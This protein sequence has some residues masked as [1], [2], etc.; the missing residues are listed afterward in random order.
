MNYHALTT[1]ALLI[2]LL[3]LSGVT[4]RAH[5]Y[6]VRAIPADQ[7][8]LERAPARVQVW[9]SEELEPA[10]SALTLRDPNGTILA[11]GGVEPNNPSLMVL[12]PPTDLP[13]GAYIVQ[14]RLAFASDGHVVNETRAFYIGER[15]AGVNSIAGASSAVPLEVVWRAIVLTASSLLLGVLVTYDRVLIPAWGNPNY[16]AGSLP[17]RV[18]R[19]MYVIAA[20]ALAL[21]W[22]GNG[23][24]LIQHAMTLFGVSFEQ[25]IANGLWNTARS[26]SQ[27]GT[28][29]T[30]RAWLLG[31]I[32]VLMGLS[33][34]WWSDKPRA[35]RPFWVAAMWGTALMLSTFAVAS[36]AAGAL[37]MA[38]VALLM[39][40]LHLTA[41]AVW[42]GGL[43]TLAFVLP[44][45]LQPY[46]HEARRLALLA[47]MR[48]FSGVAVG[49]LIVVIASGVYNALNWF[50][51]PQQVTQTRY[52]VQLIYK[53]LL[54]LGL[55]AVA[56]IHHLAANPTRYARWQAFASRFGGWG[57]TLPLEGVFAVAVIVAAGWLSAT[58]PPLPNLSNTDQPA[59]RQTVTAGDLTAEL[60][61]SPGG[62]GVN[63]YDL[64]LSQNGAPLE[65]E[66]VWIRFARP[67]LDLR[68]DW[69]PAE[70]AEVGLTLATGDDLN[71]AGEWLTLVDVI[72]DGEKT[73]LAYTW[74]FNGTG[75]VIQSL[76]PAVRHWVALAMVHLALGIVIFPTG[77]RFMR[78]L[79][80]NTLTASVIIVTAIAT[81]GVSTWGF[82]WISEQQAASRAALNPP[83]QV[84]NPTL[85]DARS[86]AA[87]EAT[88]VEACGWELDGLPYLQFIE[89]LPRVRDEALFQTTREGWNGFPPCDG[90]LSDAAR[91]DVVN[92][93]RSLEAR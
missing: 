72:H 9:F 29:W 37:V 2:V 8:V 7:A 82:W 28:V 11:E 47:V 77:Q 23:L 58:P 83:P 17:P 24:A 6:I 5:G 49:A 18:M 85:P 39:H 33:A 22:A 78:L 76:P 15:G 92:Y 61:V 57:R 51:T 80:L 10:F 21:T 55:V 46:D 42:T 68:G 65:A 56:G 14:L 59:P 34:Y 89:R 66:A 40:W 53:L 38:W 73:R 16:L 43:V 74:D 12:R 60:T 1:V 67:D 20:V 64:R 41:V 19:R 27:F 48:R 69:L 26:G 25:V 86:L 36:H 30:W 50:Y 52:G 87:G 44:V 79:N 54:T 90:A 75:G 70:P 93:W 91:W 81:A 35:M 71:Q 63:T 32:T 31:V 4:V 3:L 62:I 88:F 13:D 84:I 45:A